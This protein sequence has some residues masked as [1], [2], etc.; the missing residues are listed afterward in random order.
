[1]NLLT[2]FLYVFTGCASPLYSGVY[3]SGHF[4]DLAA[5]AFLP[6]CQKERQIRRIMMQSAATFN[7]LVTAQQ[8]IICLPKKKWDVE[9]QQS[10][11]TS[12]KQI[13]WTEKQVSDQKVL[14][15]RLLI[16]GF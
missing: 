15:R 12:G 13:A 3:V 5:V 4:N 10:K 1:M 8:Y 9:E 7:H 11:N 2:S 14:N 6:P 16:T